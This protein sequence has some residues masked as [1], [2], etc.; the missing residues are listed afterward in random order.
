MSNLFFGLL[1]LNAD[2]VQERTHGVFSVEHM[3]GFLVT[4]NII[5][6]FLLKILVD[7]L[8]LQNTQKT[9]VNLV[10]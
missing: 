7:P 1:E 9:F 10:V 4:F 5:F 8:I 2:L 3:S 6:D